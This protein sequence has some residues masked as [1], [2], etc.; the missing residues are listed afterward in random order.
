[1]A[2][3]VEVVR[4]FTGADVHRRCVHASC[5]TR[6]TAVHFASSLIWQ[7]CLLEIRGNK[8]RTGT[9]KRCSSDWH[10]C[11]NCHN[12][13][14]ASDLPPTQA[15]HTVPAAALPAT[16]SLQNGC[17]VPFSNHRMQGSDEAAKAVCKQVLYTSLEAG[18]RLLHPFMPFITEELWQRLPRR[19]SE[20]AVSIMVARFPE[21]QWV[22]CA[23]AAAEAAMECLQVVVREARALRV[24]K[25][26]KL[27]D[28]AA[29]SIL[30]LVRCQRLLVVSVPPYV[31]LIGQ[32]RCCGI[33]SGA[34]PP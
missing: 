24:A 16:A 11:G 5:W 29:L 23:D 20:T 18:L 28:D 33:P 7:D 25:G 31:G 30:S 6:S 22:G 2:K 14:C 34:Q 32:H 19:G 13:G 10:H 1:V 8:S 27:R 12:H 15:Q 26:L 9:P 17:S 21:A 4:H 3:A